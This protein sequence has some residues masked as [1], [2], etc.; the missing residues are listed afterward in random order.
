MVGPC[1][2]HARSSSSWR[3][4]QRERELAATRRGH[5][6]LGRLGHSRCEPPKGALGAAK[7]VEGHED[8]AEG[9]LE[10]RLEV[11]QGAEGLARAA[12]RPRR[13]RHLH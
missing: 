2:A 6:R 3:Q 9:P 10:G 1:T 5:G 8:D 12:Q 13:E 7:V 11:A 4:R